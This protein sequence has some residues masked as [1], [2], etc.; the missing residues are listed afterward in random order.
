MTSMPASRRARAMTFAPRSWPSSPGL[1][2]RTR[3]GAGLGTGKVY[4]VWGEAAAGRILA[5]L[6]PSRLPGLGVLPTRVGGVVGVEQE[7]F[8][9]IEE[10]EAEEEVPHEGELGDD[11]D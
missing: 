9:A 8:A 1:A 3:I 2:T 5:R 4:V 10:A 11:T 6:L 7:A